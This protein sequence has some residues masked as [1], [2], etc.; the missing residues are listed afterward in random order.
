MGEDGA[1]I[2]VMKPTLSKKRFGITMVVNNNINLTCDYCSN[3]F[4]KQ[5]WRNWK[6][7]TKK[8]TKHIFC[9]KNCAIKFVGANNKGFIRNKQTRKK[10]SSSLL[11]RKQSPETR[12]KRSLSIRKTWDDPEIREKRITGQKGKSGKYW[13]GKHKSLALRKRI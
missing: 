8:T 2:L 3:L 9:S 13:L 4:L 1:Y 5:D 7:R 10:I 12:L 6:N 11:G